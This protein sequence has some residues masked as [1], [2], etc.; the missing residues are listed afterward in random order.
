MKTRMKSVVVGLVIIIVIMLAYICTLPS[1]KSR[2]DDKTNLKWLQQIID[3]KVKKKMAMKNLY[4]PYA[5]S[6]NAKPIMPNQKDVD[7]EPDHL[8]HLFD[9]KLNSQSL[10]SE[11]PRVDTDKHLSDK[12]TLKNKLKNFDLPFDIFAQSS[13]TPLSSTSTSWEQFPKDWP[14]LGHASMTTQMRK[15]NYPIFRNPFGTTTS[16]TTRPITRHISRNPTLPVLSDSSF[17]KSY[18]NRLTD[19]H[20]VDSSLDK[21]TLNKAF[22]KMSRDVSVYGNDEKAILPSPKNEENL[23]GVPNNP[24]PPNSKDKSLNPPNILSSKTE[25]NSFNSPYNQVSSK[26]EHNSYNT[27]NKILSESKEYSPNAPYNNRLS[28]PKQS[29][30]SIIRKIPSSITGLDKSNMFLQNQ[31]VP[32][33]ETGDKTANKMTQIQPSRGDYDDIKDDTHA[34]PEKTINADELRTPV[35]LSEKTDEADSQNPS[36]VGYY[37]DHRIQDKATK[38]PGNIQ[39]NKHNQDEG[40]LRGDTEKT[41]TTVNKLK[42]NGLVDDL[43]KVGNSRIKLCKSYTIERPKYGDC[44]TLQTLTAPVQLCTHPLEQDSK[45]SSALHHRASWEFPMMRDVVL[46]MLKNP[47]SGLI[48]IGAGVGAYSIAA[49]AHGRPVIAIEPYMPHVRLLQQSIVLN[50]LQKYVSIVCNAISD[51]EEILEAEYVPGH[52][53]DV[54]WNYV[55]DSDFKTIANNSDNIVETITLDDLVE[56]INLTLAVL[57]LDAPNY[58]YKILKKAHMLFD[59][60]DIK[61][62]FMHWAGKTEIDLHGIADFFVKQNYRALERYNGKEVE[63]DMLIQSGRSDVVWEKKKPE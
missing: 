4:K 53:T 40:E 18:S 14:A 2:D 5:N 48:D 12:T 15:M 26:H 10:D 41:V 47:E 34:L 51:Y 29:D 38:N 33:K 56:V 37:E 19:I 35:A 59:K 16:S 3:E 60:V 49:A 13:S 43:T 45:V 22:E 58:D 6:N 54:V 36:K 1:I 52:L 42:T 57:K 28:L 21:E 8:N 25:Q 20:N 62:V 63:T 17:A 23:L 11:S 27:P 55:P 46:A 39:P 7:G 31:N 61:Y 30:Q 44:L 9:T 50:S 24:L 32:T